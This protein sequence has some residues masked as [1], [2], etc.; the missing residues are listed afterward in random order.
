MGDDAR[1][2]TTRTAEMEQQA[3]TNFRAQNAGKDGGQPK[4]ISDFYINRDNCLGGNSLS[5]LSAGN[6][7]IS[8]FAG[9]QYGGIK[10]RLGENGGGI[11][12]DVESI[13]PLPVHL[14]HPDAEHNIDENYTEDRSSMSSLT[15]DLNQELNQRDRSAI[16]SKHLRQIQRQR[17][18]RA[19]FL[20]EGIPDAF[21]SQDQ[22]SIDFRRRNGVQPWY[23][24]QPSQLDQ[25]NN[26]EERMPP[27][28]HEV[29]VSTPEKDLITS[30]VHI[31]KLIRSP[32]PPAH[33]LSFANSPARN[34]QSGNG[35]LAY[36]HG[37]YNDYSRNKRIIL[38]LSV[39]ALVG[40]CFGM[41]AVIVGTKDS[42]GEGK[43]N[44]KFVS[45]EDASYQDIQLSLE[46]ALTQDFIDEEAYLRDGSDAT[47]HTNASNPPSLSPSKIEL[48]GSGKS[49]APSPPP[50][51]SHPENSS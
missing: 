33:Q 27:S 11:E 47:N 26:H 24:A 15:N 45:L 28:Q 50:F 25:N 19:Q 7:T 34:D 17:S 9:E 6:T 49:I 5:S 31:N 44:D 46:E 36:V 1:Y 21:D 41:I 23:S 38:L 39:I 3:P 37:R 22:I 13:D 8:R 51:E 18:S 20:V 29:V 35:F 48:R 2:V 30:Q 40:V 4:V 16:F 12:V 14:I 10:I 42:S 43:P 32:E